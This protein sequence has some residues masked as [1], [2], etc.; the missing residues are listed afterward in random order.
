[1]T[2]NESPCCDANRSI[3]KTP[4]RRGVGKSSR[5]CLNNYG[6]PTANKFLQ[7]LLSYARSLL[8][9]LLV[10]LVG[11]KNVGRTIDNNRTTGRETLG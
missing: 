10:A 2:V 4:L 9:K 7:E 11:S 1:M 5:R 3:E 8:C 6:V